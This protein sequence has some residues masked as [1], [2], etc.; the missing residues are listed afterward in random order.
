MQL[1]KSKKRWRIAVAVCA[2]WGGVTLLSSLAG[3]AVPGLINFVDRIDFGCSEPKIVN[4]IWIRPCMNSTPH[5]HSVPLLASW[6]S[7]GG[8][9]SI[10]L[11]VLDYHGENEIECRKVVVTD[12]VMIVDD[13]RIPLLKNADAVS[14]SFVAYAG[15]FRADCYITVPDAVDMANVTRVGIESTLQIHTSDSIMTDTIEAALDREGWKG[16]WFIW[17]ALFVHA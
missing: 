15:G 13:K 3:I 8:P 2:L 9:F 12:Y 17:E 14:A 10:G 11:T 4:G 16:S 5:S 6:E 7:S 1:H